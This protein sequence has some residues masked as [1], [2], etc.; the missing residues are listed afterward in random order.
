MR[1]SSS[2]PQSSATGPSRK[3][4]S[5][6]VSFA[7]AYDRSFAQ[8]GLPLKISPSHHTSPAS[9]ASRSV[10]ESV[11]RAWRAKRKIGFEI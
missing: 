2:M 9:I 11:G 6:S 5:S 3:A 8:S 7:G 4:C 1:H 10:S